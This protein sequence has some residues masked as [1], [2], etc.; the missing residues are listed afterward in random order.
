MS[1]SVCVQGLVD[2]GKITKGQADE[3]ERAYNAHYHA[4][5][6][7]M[8][9]SAAATLASERAIAEMKA[10]LTRKK[11]L[12]ALTIQKRQ[13]IAGHLDSYNK[14]A[15][16]RDGKPIDPRSGPAL[17]SG[18]DRATYSNIADRREAIER[19]A[20]AGM[21]ALLEKF[22]SSTLGFAR[23][24][25][26]LD[27][28][29][30][31]AFGQHTGDRSAQELNDA[32]QQS[33]EYLRQRRNAAGGDT[34]KIEHWGLP[35]D[36]NSRAIR[37]AGFDA[38]KKSINDNADRATMIDRNTGQPFTDEAWNAMLKTE[39]D[40]IRSEGW[41]EREPGSQAG[42]GMLANQRAEE[43]FF[44]WKS[45]DHWKAYNDEFGRGNAY[46]AMTAH[47]RG[48][49]HDIAQMEILGPNPPA[50]V[51]WIKDTL[52]KSAR[53]DTAPGS[54]AVDRANAANAKIDRI[55]NEYTGASRRVENRAL[56]NI[57]S[58]VRS[59]QTAAKLG[60]ATLA[61]PADLAY[62]FSTRK[63]N[64]LPAANMLWQYARLLASRGTQQERV[65]AGLMARRWI[66][67]TGGQSRYLDHAF[68][69]EFSKRLAEGVV[70][71]SAL[72]RVTDAGH[73]A[74]GESFLGAL[75]D[76]S[77]HTWDKLDPAFQRMFERYG[78]GA[79]E[80]E[81]IRKTPLEMNGGVPWIFPTNVENHALGDRLLEMISRESIHAVPE[82]DLATKAALSS[83]GRPGTVAGETVKSGVLFKGFGVGAA[84]MQAHRIAVEAAR[85]P[86]SAAKYAGGLL[87]GST[88]MG[89]LSLML[90]DVIKSGKDPRAAGAKPFTDP[91]TGKLSLNPGFWGAAMAQGGGFGALGDLLKSA[92]GRAGNFAE[93]IA[94]PIMGDIG[95]TLE[96]YGSKNPA[97]DALRLARSEIP[98]GTLWYTRLAFDR[99][100][101][102]QIQQHI[103]PH[104]NRSW[105]RMQKA[106]RDE[107]TDYWWRPGK[108]APDR[109]PKF[110]NVTRGD[111]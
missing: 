61:T 60:G 15:A 5:K 22:S 96:L 55:M 27:N 62:Q 100:L 92:E 76:N 68:S 79:K 104:Y 94:G 41:S 17:F 10:K 102:D 91:K 64:G 11:L 4:L 16:A 80:W 71:G 37:N 87:M 85:S 82:P 51:Q 75:T 33:A 95:R 7:Q 48:M 38:W 24:K 26:K 107:G 25:A 90:N 18:D 49:A 65:R 8:G 84:A 99:M 42:K 54:K 69:G 47:V 83:V 108:T 43:R 97:G 23:N 72:A 21:H 28:V 110:S 36:H 35:V 12:A 34:G 46:D 98:G 59:W 74:F 70:R 2:E 29:G 45:Y 103:D 86:T 67:H 89:A 105:K 39:F 52:E 111:R 19:R 66:S 3:A 93:S 13:E 73:Q 63:F 40:K 44:K 56:A 109:A 53:T 101:A 20:F 30:R 14:G 88:L 9:S 1:I 6:G 78:M 77:V 50:T 81:Q 32:W 58:G 57:G 106:A 31:E